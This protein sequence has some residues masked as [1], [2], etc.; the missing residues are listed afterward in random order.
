[1]PSQSIPNPITGINGKWVENIDAVT[2]NDVPMQGIS[3]FPKND[4]SEI[5]CKKWNANGTIET[6]RFLPQI[7]AENNSTIKS[8]PNDFNGLFESICGQ[9]QDLR[10]YLDTL[11]DKI[12]KISRPTTRK[13]EVADES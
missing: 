9:I 10:E 4:L 5:V 6:T 11:N 3:V 13:K 1:M 7:D 8:S 2:A 12:D